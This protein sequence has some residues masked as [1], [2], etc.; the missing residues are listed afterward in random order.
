MCDY[1]M[2]CHMVAPFY[3]TNPYAEGVKGLIGLKWDTEVY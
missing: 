3:S 1:F 2:M